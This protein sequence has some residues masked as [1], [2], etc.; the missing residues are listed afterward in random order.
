MPMLITQKR[1]DLMAM[2][3]AH[4]NLDRGDPSSWPIETMER[5]LSEMDRS[6]REVLDYR[7]RELIAR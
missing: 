6:A 7:C 4:L 1:E 5:I 3:A 2:I